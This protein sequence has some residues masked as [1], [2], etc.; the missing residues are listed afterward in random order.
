MRASGVFITVLVILLIVALTGAVLVFWSGNK[1][2]RNVKNKKKSKGAE[3]RSNTAVERKK[4]KETPTPYR[5]TLV[6]SKDGACDAAKAIAGT[7][8]LDS[9]GVTP[10]LP[11]SDCD[12]SQCECRYVHRDDRRDSDDDDRRLPA[13]RTELYDRTGNINR[14][15]SSR[16]RRRSD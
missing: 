11:L 6:T 2:K 1:T 10:G 9:E 8:F 7:M 13:V 14:R 4:V 16:G 3:R 12:V 5:A 15:Q